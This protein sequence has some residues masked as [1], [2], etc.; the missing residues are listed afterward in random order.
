MNNQV[1]YYGPLEDILRAEIPDIDELRSDNWTG[2][3]YNVE[4]Y[5]YITDNPTMNDSTFKEL[6][7]KYRCVGGLK[8]HRASYEWYVTATQLHLENIKIYGDFTTSLGLN[9][10]PIEETVE[11]HY[12][13]SIKQLSIINSAINTIRY[14]TADPQNNIFLVDIGRGCSVKDFKYF[15]EIGAQQLIDY[16]KR[17]K[18][19]FS[20]MGG[21]PGI[22]ISPV[23]GSTLVY[24][25]RD[26]GLMALHSHPLQQLCN[27]QVFKQ[28]LFNLNFN[29][30]SFY[31]M[32]DNVINAILKTLGMSSVLLDDFV[33]RPTQDL[34]RDLEE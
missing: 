17:K 34:S 22:D 4:Y 29:S 8:Q 9:V 20:T 6:N 2:N 21:D 32:P 19:G 10:S 18:A 14:D 11:R 30:S 5:A 1:L 27:T 3:C 23:N 13:G 16:M 25:S 15:Y 31:D 7:R 33:P 26:Y 28:M 24:R 12:P